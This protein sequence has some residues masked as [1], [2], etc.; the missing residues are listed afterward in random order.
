MRRR[1]QRRPT[2]PQT[3]HVASFRLSTGKRE[4]RTVRSVPAGQKCEEIIGIFQ[5]P[6]KKNTSKSAEFQNLFLEEQRKPK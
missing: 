3:F 5:S 1:Q 4:E 2:L 6:V